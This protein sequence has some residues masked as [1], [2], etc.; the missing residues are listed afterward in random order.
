MGVIVSIWP[1]LYRVSGRAWG[2][3]FLTIGLVGACLG[4]R[5][6]LPTSVALSSNDYSCGIS[7][8]RLKAEPAPEAY[9]AIPAP[10]RPVSEEDPKPRSLNS[11]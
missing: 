4:V 7:G 8:D 1:P 2:V 3:A 6:R 5:A 9:R 10:Q 11:N